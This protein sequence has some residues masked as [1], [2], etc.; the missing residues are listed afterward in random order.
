MVGSRDDDQDAGL[1]DGVI[2]LPREPVRGPGGCG[3]VGCMNGV[4]I[5]F[6]VALVVMLIVL[7]FRIWIAPPPPVP[8]Y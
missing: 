1:P 6:A 8:R 5:F 7:A 3:F 2:P 4:M